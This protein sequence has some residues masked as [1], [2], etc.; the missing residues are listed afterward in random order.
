[1]LCV[2]LPCCRYTTEFVDLGNVSALR[3]FRVLRALKTISVISGEKNQ[4]ERQGWRAHMPGPCQGCLPE[5]PSDVPVARIPFPEPGQ[6]KNLFPWNLR[7]GSGLFTP[8]KPTLRHQ[9]LRTTHGK[10][11]LIAPSF[12]KCSIVSPT[13]V[14]SA[15]QE[16]TCSDQETKN[17][18][19]LWETGIPLAVSL[20]SPTVTHASL[21]PRLITQSVLCWQASSDLGVYQ[22]SLHGAV[23][24]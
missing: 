24:V 13:W 3:T 15:L 11:E 18:V 10:A 6:R 8:A 16:V 12:P 22:P 21:S 14:K 23:E 2:N 19:C 4:V 20:M 1:M 7:M 9:G 5:G 17:G